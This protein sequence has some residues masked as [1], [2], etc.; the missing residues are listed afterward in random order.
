MEESKSKK[1]V[2]KIKIPLIV[3]IV[4][5]LVVL[6]M[7]KKEIKMKIKVKSTLE[8][9]VEKSDLETIN[10]TYNVIAKK[11][12]DESNCDK[13][14]N[15][16]D[17]FSYVASC[18]GTITAGIDFQ[19]VQVDVDTKNKKILVTMPEATIIGEPNILSIKLLNGNELAASETPNA[20]KLCQETTKE[21]SENDEKLIPAA[22]EQ[23]RVV[24]ESFYKQWIKS[25]DASYSVEVK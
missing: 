8:K 20:R 9:V 21:K 15:N 23:S 13:T 2:I 19:Q 10:I 17:D 1:R 18:K 7:P 22:K 11:C 16:I 25:Y 14:S 4:L 12:K 24:L 3:I 5:V 6:L